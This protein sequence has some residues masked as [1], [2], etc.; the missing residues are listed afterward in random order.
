MPAGVGVLT[1]VPGEP[2]KQFPLA[3]FR[4]I[5]AALDPSKRTD[6]QFGLVIVHRWDGIGYSLRGLL[7]SGPLG[8]AWDRL[9]PLGTA[10]DRLGP[11]GIRGTARDHSGS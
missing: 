2:R 5:L 8:T 6:A 3:D 10:W 4:A 9:G 11:L 7:G 1:A